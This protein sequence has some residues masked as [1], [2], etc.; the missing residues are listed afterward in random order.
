MSRQGL[1]RIVLLIVCAASVGCHANN[2]AERGAG[3][4]ALAGAATGAALADRSGNAATGAVVGSAV[5]AITGAAMGSSIDADVARNEMI[6]EQRMGRRMASAVMIDDV[7]AMTQAGLSPVVIKNHIRAKG[8]GQPIEVGEL[9]AM[10]NA[11]VSDDVIQAMQN[12][13]APQLDA[14][15]VRT[16]PAAT[17]VIVEEHHYGPYY[18]RPYWHP[19]PRRR[20]PAFCPPPRPR[21]GFS[22]SI[23]N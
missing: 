10:R 3:F 8:V 9:I 16:I 11:G 19:H 18:G 1:R 22:F 5:G 15:P 12:G 17:P 21:S 2:Y 14:R 23:R 20:P 6:I 4:G 7:I 13:Q